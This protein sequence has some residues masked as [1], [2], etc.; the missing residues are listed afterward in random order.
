MNYV[1]IFYSLHAQ[2]KPLDFPAMLGAG[3]HNIN[4][5]GVDAAVTYDVSQLRNILFNSI[6]SSGKELTQI[7]WK[8]LA[9]IYPGFL[10]QRFH[11]RP[12]TASIQR[13]SVSGEKDHAGADFFFFGIV[14]QQLSQLAGNQNGSALALAIH[15][16][17]ALLHI[18][19]REE[20]QL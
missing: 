1:R 9:G 10:T 20:P 2:P 15:N 18:L 14:Q 11:L 17:L 12:D 4:A 7:V 8:D 5:G 19:H 3:G 13:F 6:K 16:D